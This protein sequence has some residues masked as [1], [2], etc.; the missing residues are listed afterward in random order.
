[1]GILPIGTGNLFARNLN[2]PVDDFEAALAIAT[3]HGSRK[4]DVGRLSLLDRPE[5]DHPHA[6]MIIGGVGFDAQMIEETDPELKKNISWLAYFVSGAKN[7]F[8]PKY[9]ATIT[10]TDAHGNTHQVDNLVFRTFLAGNCGEIP[11]FSLMPSASYDDGLLDFEIIDTSGGLLGWANL[12][13][14]VVHQTIT[15]KAQQSPLST[16]STIEQMQG[17]SAEIKLEKPALAEVDGDTLGET[18]HILITVDHQSLTVRAPE[19][20]PAKPEPDAAVPVAAST[21]SVASARA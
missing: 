15:K 17:V 18:R 5:E 11:M 9:K 16:N 20:N 6:F 8:A 4:V 7:L 14:D 10:V 21:P 12:F 1:M 19:G 2:I 13:N 3:S